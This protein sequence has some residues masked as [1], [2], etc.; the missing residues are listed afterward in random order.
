MNPRD[1]LAEQDKAN[2]V[3]RTKDLIKIWIIQNQSIK[4]WKDYGGLDD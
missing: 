3:R 1:L 2:Q 4:I